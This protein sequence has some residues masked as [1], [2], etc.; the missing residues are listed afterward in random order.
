MLGDSEEVID[1]RRES[2][3]EDHGEGKEEAKSESDSE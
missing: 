1:V 3:S 2:D